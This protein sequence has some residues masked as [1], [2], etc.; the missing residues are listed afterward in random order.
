MQNTSTATPCH[1]VHPRIRHV[2]LVTVDSADVLASADPRPAAIGRP[3]ATVL[4]SPST[5]HPRIHRV[6]DVTFD[7][8]GVLAPACASAD[9]R[10]DT[11]DAARSR[12]ARYRDTSA[13]AT[14][15]KPR[16]SEDHAGTDPPADATNSPATAEPPCQ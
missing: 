5:N 4:R 8:T 10:R 7:A 1:P 16:C 15:Q 6:D 12:R 3:T 2:D 11:V 13:A 9:S 14:C